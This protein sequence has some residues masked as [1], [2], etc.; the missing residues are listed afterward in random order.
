MTASAADRNLLLGVLALQM[1]F[2]GRDELIAAMHAWVLEKATPLGQV[3]VQRGALSADTQALLEA[4]VDKHLV[5]HGG[6]AEK[7]LAAV[8]PV[9]AVQAALQHIADPDLQESLG[10][11]GRDDGRAVDPLR[12][13]TLAAAETDVAGPRFQILR[14]HARGGLGEVFVAR[15]EELH[16]EVALKEI[17][18]RHAH[19]ADSRTRFVMEAEITGGLEHPGIVPVYSLGYYADGRP[20]YAMR[21]IRGESL[22]EAIGRFHASE[23]DRSPDPGRRSLQ[24]RLLLQRF[25]AVCNAV[26]YAHSRGVLHRDLKPANIML[27]RY[28]E[29]LVV[30]WGLAKPLGRSDTAAAA[31]EPLLEPS[32]GSGSAPTQMGSAVGTPQYMSPEQAAGRLDKLG[33]ASDVYSLGATLYCLLTGRSPFAEAQEAGLADTLSR[34]QRGDFPPPRRLNPQ[35][36]PGLEAICLRAMALAPEDR[37]GSPRALADDLEHWLADEPVAAHEESWA[38]RAARWARRHRTLVTA[39]AALL[40]AAVTA[41]SAGLVLLGGKQAEI[42]AQRNAAQQA[43]DEAEAINTFYEDHVLAAARPKGWSGG[44]GK[45][46]TLQEALD[47]AAPT[48]DASLARQPQVEAAVR[49]TL[50]MTY[51][52]LGQFEAAGPQLEQALAIR[53]DRLGADHPDTLATLHNLAMLR[54]KQGQV[55]ESVALARQAWEGRRRVLGQD[56]ADTLWTQLWLGLLL[57]EDNQRREAEAVL[58][59]GVAAAGRILGPDDYRTLHGQHDL[60][61]IVF[62]SGRSAEAT[63]LMRQAYEGRRRSLGPEHPDTLRSMG[64]LGSLLTDAGELDESEV[65][66]RRSLEARRRVLGADHLETLWSEWYLGGLLDRKGDYAEA[67]TVLRHCLE[68]SQRLRGLNHPD[69]LDYLSALGAV[70]CHAGRAAEAEPLL[71]ECLERSARVRPSGS[72]RTA[73][74][75]CRLGE[76]LA[77]QGQHA[78]AETQLLAGYEELARGSPARPLADAAEQLAALYDTWGKPEQA[79]VWKARRRGL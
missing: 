64:V 11:V 31:A 50:G 41:L 45:D 13:R 51:W 53:R 20:Y 15:D 55:K 67:E 5:L 71:R 43:R 40:L 77:A 18:Q 1:D 34:V 36:S 10:H 17:Q 21:L 14:P 39:A 6:Q 59:E 62:G 49:N 52:Y 26:E 74:A 72:W 44:A 70:L 25:I 22:Q 8:S 56:H 38:A 60:A 35:L 58:R 27:G 57:K 63:A 9:P 33:P 42:V 29:T 68:A 3:L 48:I 76:C 73:Q 46:V 66:C 23:K 54:W 65:L 24:L 37:Y 2:V 28:G 79:A 30:D 47:Q 69:T 4:L 19:H 32:S 78:E 16:R 12:T 7:S 61:L 75:R